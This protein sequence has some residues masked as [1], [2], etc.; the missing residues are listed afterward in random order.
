MLV[1]LDEI[2]IVCLRSIDTF[3]GQ[4]TAYN[5]VVVHVELHV[6]QTGNGSKFVSHFKSCLGAFITSHSLFMASTYSYSV[7]R[8]ESLRCPAWSK[9]VVL[10]FKWVLLFTFGTFS[11]VL[12]LLCQFYEVVLSTRFLFQRTLN[13][14]TDC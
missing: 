11:T 4:T 8:N 7:H 13:L 10:L 3:R 5:V 12:S 9:L 2:L 1:V 14:V 6:F